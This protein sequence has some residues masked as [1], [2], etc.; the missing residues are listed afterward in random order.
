[1]ADEQPVALGDLDICYLSPSPEMVHLKSELE[2]VVVVTVARIRWPELTLDAAALL[3]HGKLSLTRFDFSI[4]EAE[5]ADFLCRSVEVRDRIISSKHA[6]GP[7]FTLLFSPWSRHNNAQL[8][9]VPTLGEL[10]IHG[11]P[12]HTWEQRT[13]E[14]LL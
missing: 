1:M 10:E 5:P 12:S 14:A 2:R 7:C 6:V 4:R 11:I 13:A 9:E 3:I 8:A